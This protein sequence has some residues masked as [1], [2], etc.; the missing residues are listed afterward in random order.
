[1]KKSSIST[2]IRVLG[3]LFTLLMASIVTTTIYLNN[4]NSQDAMIINIAGKQR[5]LTQNISKN[6]LKQTFK[7]TS[8]TIEHILS[9]LPDKKLDRSSPRK[10]K[11]SWTFFI[12]YLEMWIFFCIFYLV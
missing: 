7:N 5:M 9:K 11:K 10:I 8:P 6:I 12:F 4:N 1:M 3:I 2:K